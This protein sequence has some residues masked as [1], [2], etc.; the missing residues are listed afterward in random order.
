[1]KTDKRREKI[2]RIALEENT[3]VITSRNRNRLAIGFALLLL[4]IFALILRM[5]YWQ[6]YK[7]DELKVMAIDMQK[8]DTEIDPVRGAIYDSRMNTLAE[9]VTEYELYAYTQFLYKDEGISNDDKAKAVLRLSEITGSDPA[10]MQQLLEGGY[11][12]C[13][14]IATVATDNQNGHH[15]CAPKDGYSRVSRR[16][17]AQDLSV[18]SHGFPPCQS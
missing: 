13:Y 4:V 8:V 10:A 2:R 7:S 17:A 1:M 5:G 3:G 6:I 11:K 16:R 9:T 15:I 12:P 18:I 14:R